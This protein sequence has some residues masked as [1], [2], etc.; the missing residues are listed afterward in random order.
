MLVKLAILLQ[1]KRT[2]ISRIRGSI[3]SHASDVVGQDSHQNPKEALE[4]LLSTHVIPL[5]DNIEQSI[6][7]QK[8][9]S[10]HISSITLNG[11]YIANVSI[12]S[13]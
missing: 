10:N 11:Q 6:K 8:Q 2:S 7:Q 5:L 4:T 9:S 1:S 3:S 12:E 13:L